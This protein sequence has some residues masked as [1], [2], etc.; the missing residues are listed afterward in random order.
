MVNSGT[1]RKKYVNVQVVINGMDN[2]VTKLMIVLGIEFGMK[3]LSNVCVQMVNTGMEEVVQFNLFVMEVSFGILGHFSVCVLVV[4]S[5]IQLIVW[6]VVMGRYGMNHQEHVYVQEEQFGWIIYVGWSRSVKEGWCGIKISGLVS[7][8]VQQFGMVTI[9]F[10]ILVPMDGSGMIPIDHVCARITK[11]G[12]VKHAY[13]QKL[14]VQ[15]VDFGIPRSLLVFVLLVPSLVS[16][17]VIRYL[18]VEMDRYIT[19]LITS[20]N[21]HMGWSFSALVVSS[22]HVWMD[23]FGMVTHVR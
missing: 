7:V 19:L 20:V 11:F 3:L 12:M 13:L 23:S 15:M 1:N 21:V 2:S 8:Q 18:C 17:N 9:V 14:L 5:G 10:L 4:V 6:D 22:Q 16:A